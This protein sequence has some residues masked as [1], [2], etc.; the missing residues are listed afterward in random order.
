MARASS[1]SPKIDAQHTIVTEYACV[2]QVALVYLSAVVIVGAPFEY[3]PWVLSVVLLGIFFFVITFAIM[4]QLVTGS[5]QIEVEH[6]I[7]EQEAREIDLRLTLD[8]MVGCAVG[9]TQTQELTRGD[10]ILSEQA[11]S[12]H[13]PRKLSVVITA[14]GKRANRW[15]WAEG[16]TFKTPRKDGFNSTFYPCFVMEIKIMCRLTRLPFHEDALDVH[17]LEELK[18]DSRAPSPSHT[19]FISQARRRYPRC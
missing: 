15:H 19:Y 2:A 1:L 3:T 8:E 17:E 13:A 4:L 14:G 6:R 10:Q 9:L 5:S 16:Q 12:A 11:E 18:P 7:L